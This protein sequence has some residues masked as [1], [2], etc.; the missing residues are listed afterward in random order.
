M[1]VRLAALLM[2]AG[3]TLIGPAALAQRDPLLSY[4]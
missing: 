1:W 2:L 3:A 4:Q